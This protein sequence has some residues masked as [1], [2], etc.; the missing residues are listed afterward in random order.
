MHALESAEQKAKDE[1]RHAILDLEVA[2]ANRVKADEQLKLAR[3][4]NELVQHAFEAGTNTPVDI[5]DANA[6]LLGAE[7]VKLAEDLNAQVATLR[8]AKASGA[9]EP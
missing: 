7:L 2:R 9:F 6:A 3:E 1:V 8:L 5:A 4:N